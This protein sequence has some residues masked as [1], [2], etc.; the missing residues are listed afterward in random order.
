MNYLSIPLLC[1]CSIQA[2]SI[3]HHKKIATNTSKKNITPS[4]I[5][6]WVIIYAELKIKATIAETLLISNKLIAIFHG[7]LFHL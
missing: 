2:H 5:P 1:L 6:F 3:N 7:K 4:S